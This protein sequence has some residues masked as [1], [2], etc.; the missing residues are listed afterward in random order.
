MKPV[1]PTDLTEE[2][3]LQISNDISE[4]MCR[5]SRGELCAAVRYWA[6]SSAKYAHKL[7]ATRDRVLTFALEENLKKHED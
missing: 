3:I 7:A 2:R 5:A 4:G 1:E 6:N